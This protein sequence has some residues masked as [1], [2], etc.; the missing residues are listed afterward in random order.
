MPDQPDDDLAA[1]L[2]ASTAA[3]AKPVRDDLI[4]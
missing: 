3:Y 2:K 4:L 1:A